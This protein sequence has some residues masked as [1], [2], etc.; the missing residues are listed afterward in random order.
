[1]GRRSPAF[2]RERH[3]NSLCD[4]TKKQL[5]GAA[6]GDTA[7]NLFGVVPAAVFA[8]QKLQIYLGREVAIELFDGGFDAFGFVVNGKQNLY[9]VGSARGHRFTL[10]KGMG[11]S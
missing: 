1:M 9:V 5:R 7:K 11:A 6:G 4:F 8:Q 2:R 3:T 10:G